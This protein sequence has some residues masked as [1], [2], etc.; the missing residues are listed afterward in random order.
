MKILDYLALYEE[1]EKEVVALKEVLREASSDSKNTL[2]P[3][4]EKLEKEL[5]MMKE[6]IDQTHINTVQF[7]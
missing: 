7:R 1:K 4:I 5:A 3:L 6:R 2:S